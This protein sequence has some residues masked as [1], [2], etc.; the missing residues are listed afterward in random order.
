[1]SNKIDGPGPGALPPLP[2]KKENSPATRMLGP[3]AS[4]RSAKPEDS[5]R[6]EVTDKALKMRRLEATIMS[7][8]EVDEARVEAIRSRL[9][10]GDF[11]VNKESI[12]D[13]LLAMEKDLE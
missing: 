8:P 6:V 5:A 7:M 12:A 4:D 2:G 1:M 11:A 9:A 13:K 3:P 10:R